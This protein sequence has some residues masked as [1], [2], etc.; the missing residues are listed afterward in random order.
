MIRSPDLRIEAKRSGLPRRCPLT[1]SP[2]AGAYHAM[3]APLPAY[4]G[5]T[6]WDL[7]PLPMIIGKRLSAPSVSPSR[8]L[9]NR[10]FFDRRS[11]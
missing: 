3:T 10:R 11:G 8:R 4:S 9:D 7:H 1:T 5:G 6:V 2:V